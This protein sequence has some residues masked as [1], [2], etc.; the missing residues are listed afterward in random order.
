MLDGKEISET[1]K[2]FLLNWKANRDARK[3]QLLQRQK[4]AQELE[5][6]TC[7]EPEMTSIYFQTVPPSLPP[8]NAAFAGSYP[9]RISSGTTLESGT[10]GTRSQHTRLIIKLGYNK[11]TFSQV[12]KIYYPMDKA[13]QTLNNLPLNCCLELFY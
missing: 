11:G 7:S 6:A 9:R 1:T 8:L 13:V 5:K 10:S 2:R 12:R 4:R 3:R